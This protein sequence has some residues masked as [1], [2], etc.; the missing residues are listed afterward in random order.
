MKLKCNEVWG[1]NDQGWKTQSWLSRTFQVAHEDNKIIF[2]AHL[3]LG[4]VGFKQWNQQAQ[5]DFLIWPKKNPIPF[6]IQAF[7]QR[8]LP[9]YNDFP[10]WEISV[11]G[12]LDMFRHHSKFNLKSINKLCLMP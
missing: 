5:A 2:N 10:N 11:S 6:L 7:L 8:T 12:L 9:E 4:L 1:L 3:E